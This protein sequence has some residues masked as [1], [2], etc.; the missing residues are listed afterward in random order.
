M[1]PRSRAV[2]II[3]CTLLIGLAIGTLIVAPMLA[4]HHFR[5]VARLR[6]TDGFVSRLE[7]KIEPSPGQAEAVKG[8]LTRYGEELNRISSEHH[9]ELSTMLD[10]MKAELDPI[11]TEE[12]KERLA[13]RERHRRPF[14][15]EERP[16]KG[17]RPPPP[18]GKPN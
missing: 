16:E 15:H 3:I 2:V 12:Q 1:S 7:E 4:R 11:L 6:T 9:T 10:S 18:F 5:R 13:R 8:I 14:D 17:K